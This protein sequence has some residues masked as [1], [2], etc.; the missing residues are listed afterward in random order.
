VIGLIAAVAATAGDLVLLL[1]SNAGRPGL[2]W[3]PRPSDGALVAGTYLGVVAIP[4]YGLGY[5]EVARSFADERV[6][7]WITAL[8]TTGGVLGGTTH[9]LTGLVVHVTRTTGAPPGDPVAVL[10]PYGAYLLPLWTAIALVSIAGALV[11][12]AA[13]ARGAST[14]PRWMALGNP[15]VL[16]AALGLVGAGGEVGRALLVPAS[17]NLAHVIFFALVTTTARPAP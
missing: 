8:G 16:A 12:G 1:A 15:L 5:C 3:L 7:W 13:V 6:R 9:G 2:E 4:C 14:L 10:A 11:Y 17:P